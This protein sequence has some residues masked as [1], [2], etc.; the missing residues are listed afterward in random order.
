ML[1]KSGLKVSLPNFRAMLGRE[2]IKRPLASINELKPSSTPMQNKTNGLRPSAKSQGYTATRFGYN[3]N[4]DG[5]SGE[6]ETD[7]CN[8]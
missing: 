5:F 7:Q 1:K 8:I 6:L 4:K 3:Q 2:T